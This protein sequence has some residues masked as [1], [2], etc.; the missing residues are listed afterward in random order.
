MDT[1]QSINYDLYDQF[2]QGIEF[3]FPTYSVNLSGILKGKGNG[4]EFVTSAGEPLPSER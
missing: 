3:A 2:E 4:L 1:Q